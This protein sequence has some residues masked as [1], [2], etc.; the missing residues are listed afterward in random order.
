MEKLRLRP[1]H[2]LCIPRYFRGGYNKE[3]ADNFRRICFSIREKPYLDI[4]IVLGCD[5][6]CEKCSYRQDNTCTKREGINELILIQDR[7][8]LETLKIKTGDIFKAKDI[9]T[10]SINKIKN[11]DLEKFCKIYRGCDYLN[12]CISYGFNKSFVK[13][14]SQNGNRRA[15]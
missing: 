14:I 11:E 7:K 1:H 15:S 3:Y 9:F 2:L 4:E 13:N 8:V 12:S 10:L 6:V 5:D